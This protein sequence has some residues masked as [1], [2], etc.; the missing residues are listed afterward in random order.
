MIWQ[1]NCGRRSSNPGLDG[2][3]K[4]TWKCHFER[5]RSKH[6]ELAHTDTNRLF[7]PGCSALTWRDECELK[8]RCCRHRWRPCGPQEA[9]KL[10]TET[11]PSDEDEDDDDDGGDEK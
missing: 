5:L 3:L 8:S 7:C 11:F 4:Q 2:R 6:P 9:V 1:T 10:S